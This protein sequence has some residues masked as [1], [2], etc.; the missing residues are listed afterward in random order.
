M[1]TGEWSELLS[2]GQGG[3][4][5]GNFRAHILPSDL[6][7]GNRKVTESSDLYD[8]CWFEGSDKD[9]LEDC[10]YVKSAFV[11]SDNTYLDD[12]G[13]AEDWYD[14]VWYYFGVGTPC[15]RTGSQAMSMD[16][17]AGG[18]ATN[19]IGTWLENYVATVYRSY[20]YGVV[21]F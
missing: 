12:I 15:G 6:Y 1:P 13:F 9:R 14:W 8:G 20:A 3:S 5:V 11:S 17:G 4:V 2:V 16:Q 19:P 21:N 7:F 18:Y 10:H